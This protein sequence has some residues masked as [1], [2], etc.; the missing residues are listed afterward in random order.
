[1]VVVDEASI[2]SKA[3]GLGTG[4]LR[5]RGRSIESVHATLI[6]LDLPLIGHQYVIVLHS[7]LIFACDLVG[8]DKISD[9]GRGIWFRLV[10]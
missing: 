3:I 4:L 5:R 6:R 10:D 8:R 2:L 1:M 9:Q 7:I